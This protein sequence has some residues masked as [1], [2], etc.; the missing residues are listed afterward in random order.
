MYLLIQCYMILGAGIGH[1]DRNFV[2]SPSL[3][4]PNVT[5]MRFTEAIEQYLPGSLLERKGKIMG[6]EENQAHECLFK[7]A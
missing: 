2:Q 5:H 3:R 7:I 4:I 1:N 6:T